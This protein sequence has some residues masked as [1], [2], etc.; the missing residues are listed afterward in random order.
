MALLV[1]ELNEADLL[2]NGPVVSYD[3]ACKL[4][5]L[6]AVIREAMRMHPSVGMIL[7]RGVPLGGATLAL[8]SGEKY[9]VGAGAEIGFNPW[10]MHRDPDI[11]PDPEVF[12]PER[13]IVS[14]AEHLVRMNR[15]WMSFGGG[16]HS[17]SGQHISVL[18]MAKL[19]P[20][21]VLRYDMTWEEGAPDI[22][23]ENYF[24]T[25]Q[26]GLRIRLERRN[27]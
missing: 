22:K 17:C 26:N 25:V 27:S 19:I 24:F 14:D 18:E 3:E 11:F 7:A 5:Y 1:T 6:S 15:A 8:E 4:P 16:R 2:K 12:K 10:I 9:H 20:S 21:L 13:W 23:V